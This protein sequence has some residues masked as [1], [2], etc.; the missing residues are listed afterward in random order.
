MRTQKEGDLTPWWIEKTATCA[1]CGGEF[2]FEDGDEPTI[3]PGVDRR[4]PDRA[5]LPCPTE[6]CDGTL[7]VTW[8]SP[9]SAEEQ[10][11]AD[12]EAERIRA[13]MIEQ[14]KRIQEEAEKNPPEIV[15]IVEDQEPIREVTRPPRFE[16]ATE[17]TE[18]P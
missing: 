5:E 16:I 14:M 1:T 2:V 10:A 7:S 9:L 8:Q 15:E 11:K 13:E 12:I 18:T 4:T 17:A 3:V 6:D